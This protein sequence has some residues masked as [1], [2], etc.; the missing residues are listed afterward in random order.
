MGGNVKT[1]AKFVTGEI[2]VARA[3]FGEVTVLTIGYPRN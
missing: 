1:V 2:V 3:V